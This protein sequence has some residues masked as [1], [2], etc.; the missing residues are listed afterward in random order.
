MAAFEDTAKRLHR[1]L[2]T[3]VGHFVVRFGRFPDRAEVDLIGKLLLDE[4]D[5]SNDPAATRH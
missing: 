2:M 3:S 5:S 1:L 4:A